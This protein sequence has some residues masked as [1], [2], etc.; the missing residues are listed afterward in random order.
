MTISGKGI[1]QKMARSSWVEPDTMGL[2]LAALMP[3][4]RLV[5]EVI[6][7]TGLRVSDV[8]NIT[9]A[10]VERGRFTVREKKTGK[11]RRVYL[12]RKLQLRILGQAGRLWAFEGRLDWRRPRTRAAVYK[13]V[14]R[15]A[16]MFARTGRI[17][18]AAQIS[19]HSGR[20]VYAVTEYHRTGSLQKTG[21][22]LNHDAA[23]L[24]TT[25]L[26]ALCDAIDPKELARM[27][28][29]KQH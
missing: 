18:R 22:A 25:M 5:M 9:R 20:K 24:A 27:A 29:K 3:A 1:R 14:K 7:Q 10:Q 21:Q 16:A 15:A 2:V 13:D 8:L 6:I 23:H 11:T 19:P 17:D 4:N 26:Y 12:P 28:A